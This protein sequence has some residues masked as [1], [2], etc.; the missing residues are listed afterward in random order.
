MTS[1]IV[2]S[3]STIGTTGTVTVTLGSAPTIG[4]TLVGIMAADAY[5]TA[6]PTA[7]S[8]RS[9]TSQAV[10][11]EQPRVLPVDAPGRVG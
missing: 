11:R 6:A 5:Q 9:Y 2:Q 8:G 4:N 7:G 3:A 10:H 1:S